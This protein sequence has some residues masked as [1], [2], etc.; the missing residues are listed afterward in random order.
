MVNSRLVGKHELIR[1]VTKA[2][3]TK[4]L[5]NGILGNFDPPAGPTGNTENPL[6]RHYAEAHETVHEWDTRHLELDGFVGGPPA[7]GKRGSD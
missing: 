6:C 3:Y 7:S 2:Y 1:S 4:C 5:E